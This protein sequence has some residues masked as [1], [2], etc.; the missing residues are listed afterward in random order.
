MA[1]MQALVPIGLMEDVRHPSVLATHLQDA[2]SR[3]TLSIVRL[4]LSTIVGPAESHCNIKIR[5]AAHL[6]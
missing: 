3:P 6:L 5:K 2:G 1:V 4:T